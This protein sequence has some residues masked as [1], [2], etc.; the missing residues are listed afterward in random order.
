MV[1]DKLLKQPLLQPVLPEC[2]VN[3]K[4][5]REAV[6]VCESLAL[7]WDSLKYANGKDIIQARSVVQAAIVSS[8]RRVIVLA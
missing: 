6:N 7:A 2:V 1:I 5:L 8:T 3:Q 4:K